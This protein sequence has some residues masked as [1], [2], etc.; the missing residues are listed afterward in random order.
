MCRFL[1]VKS[2][3]PIKPENLLTR[4]AKMAKNSR[5]YDG[6]QQSDGWGIAWLNAQKQWQLKKSLSPIWKELNSFTQFPD[7]NIFVV[8]AR[9]SSFPKDKGFIIYN[10]PYIDGQ[11]SFVFN[12]LLKGV[13]LPEI[14]G[15][16]GAEKIWYLLKRELKKNDIP[17]ALENTKK[18]LL[19]NSKEIIAF[20]LGLAD[21]QKSKIYSLCYFTKYPQYY[22]LHTSKTQSLEIICS[23][24]LPALCQTETGGQ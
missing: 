14:P 7:S 13:S 16:I 20:N 3:K 2:Q 10:Q 17:V 5:S 19:K 23:E 9:S 1:L 22:Q 6:D 21:S 11:Y 8:H 12:G 4:F 24:N 15:N 18:L